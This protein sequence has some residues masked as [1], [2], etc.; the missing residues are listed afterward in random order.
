MLHFTDHNSAV[1]ARTKGDYETRGRREIL[2]LRIAAS[3]EEARGPISQLV[4][5]MCFARVFFAPLADFVVNVG[6]KMSHY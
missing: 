4:Y 6:R 1:A 2:G 5:T 3:K